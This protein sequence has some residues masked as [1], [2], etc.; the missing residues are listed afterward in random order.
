MSGSDWFASALEGAFLDLTALCVLQHG[1]TI[2]LPDAYLFSLDH[3]CP[4]SH[5]DMWSFKE[6]V[7]LA[8]GSASSDTKLPG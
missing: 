7:D 2:R 6:H 3:V 4:C 5:C 8:E 1:Q